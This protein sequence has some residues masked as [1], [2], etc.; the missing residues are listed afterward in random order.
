MR[1]CVRACVRV[2]VCVSLLLQCLCGRGCLGVIRCTIEL[3]D[4]Q[5]YEAWLEKK[6][7]SASKPPASVHATA[8]ERKKQQREA[9]EASFREWQVRT[10][11]RVRI[12]LP[13]PHR[14]LVRCRRRRRAQPRR[15][16]KR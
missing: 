2:C 11:G 7:P 3:A 9:A 5:S 6:G 15:I 14:L 4:S 1:A 10:H 12:C 16:R 13:W 8:L